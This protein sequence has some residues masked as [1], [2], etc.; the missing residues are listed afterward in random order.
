MAS[1]F[2]LR[3]PFK[4]FRIWIPTDEADTALDLSA[5]VEGFLSMEKLLLLWFVN[6]RL[7]LGKGEDQ[8]RKV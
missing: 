7:H 8:I 4:V 5:S 6:F 3:S 1:I 2:M